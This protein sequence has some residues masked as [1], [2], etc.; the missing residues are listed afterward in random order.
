[1][2]TDDGRVLIQGY[3]ISSDD[4]SSV[5]LPSGEDAVYMTVETLKK[6]VESL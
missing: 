5:V 3:T 2:I 6:L 1:M 4:R